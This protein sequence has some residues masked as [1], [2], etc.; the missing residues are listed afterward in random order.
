MMDQAP[1][2]RERHNEKIPHERERLEHMER[3]ADRLDDA[4]T[5]IMDPHGTV[6]EDEQRRIELQIIADITPL[7]GKEIVRDLPLAVLKRLEGAPT[8]KML[9]YCKYLERIGLREL[10]RDSN[11]QK[12]KFPTLPPNFTHNA[13]YGISHII[14]VISDTETH[15]LP[16]LLTHAMQEKMFLLPDSGEDWLY[17][18][19]QITNLDGVRLRSPVHQHEKRFTE[20]LLRQVHFEP[21]LQPGETAE[22]LSD[23]VIGI[24]NEFGDLLRVAEVNQEHLPSPHTFTRTKERELKNRAQYMRDGGPGMYRGIYWYGIQETC[25]DIF[26]KLAENGLFPAGKNEKNIH[27][28]QEYVSRFMHLDSTRQASTPLEMRLAPVKKKFLEQVEQFFTGN[29]DLQLDSNILRHM[30]AVPYTQR[31]Q[32]FTQSNWPRRV[33]DYIQSGDVTKA[34]ALIENYTG[35]LY[36]M[37]KL[38]MQ[39]SAESL[40]IMHLYESTNRDIA[41]IEKNFIGSDTLLPRRRALVEP[42]HPIEGMRPEVRLIFEHL[43]GQRDRVAAVIE[44]AS[45]ELADDRQAHTIELQTVDIEQL[46]QSSKWNPNP[47]VNTESLYRTIR[48]V[49]DPATYMEIEMAY[50]ITLRELTFATQIQ[51]VQFLLEAS[52]EVDR[53]LRKIIREFNG[54]PYS[55]L[56]SFLALSEDPQHAMRLL[57]ILEQHDNPHIA[58]ILDSYADITRRID[59]IE[60]YI[61]ENVPS[62]SETDVRAVVST[63][64]RR[65]NRMLFGMTEQV[66]AGEFEGLADS[67]AQMNSDVIT[68]AALCERTVKRNPDIR[69]EDLARVNFEHVHGAD[70][71]DHHKQ[72]LLA[73]SRANYRSRPDVWQEFQSLLFDPARQKQLAKNTFIILERDSEEEGNDPVLMSFLRVEELREDTVYFGSLNVNPFARSAG[74]AEHIA[75]VSIAE[76][77]EHKNIE[78]I[79]IPELRAA[80]FYVDDLGF[81]VVGIEPHEKPGVPSYGKLQLL[82]PSQ[83]VQQKSGVQSRLRQMSRDALRTEFQDQYEGTD[84]IQRQGEDHIIARSNIDE[85]LEGFCR[86]L[87]TLLNDPDGYTLVRFLCADP[88]N[89]PSCASRILAFEKR[90]NE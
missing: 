29:T 41:F 89:D 7:V 18:L 47:T 66:E 52:P 20:D 16:H 17:G 76:Y 19:S 61:A 33:Q 90:R 28:L 69:L 15:I 75:P 42:M 36:E 71:T 11:A 5:R 2:R 77:H 46:L 39:L 81:Q 86:L 26:Y 43:E 82:L 22:F 73:V 67:F 38:H 54:S 37:E 83:H 79:V 40:Q 30:S 32:V 27:M 24:R 49:Y 68:F 88:Q 25:P 50:D 14:N 44:E 56:E 34:Y 58:R 53:R 63:L 10:H 21:E 31:L 84:P 74:I 45:Q 62:A 1:A 4:V 59:G 57:D 35:I 13:M 64:L 12:K 78:A 65:A 48:H 72:Q 85:D 55:F 70:L 87:T 51:F 3:I 80:Q 60:L 6:S 8:Y 23:T 9:D